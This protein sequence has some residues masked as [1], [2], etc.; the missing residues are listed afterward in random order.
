MNISVLIIDGL[1]T[2]WDV[3]DH[4]IILIYISA[5][6]CFDHSHVSFDYC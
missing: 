4:A 5:P 6:G 2:A 3:A 1:S